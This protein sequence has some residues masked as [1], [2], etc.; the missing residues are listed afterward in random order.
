MSLS[1]AVEP[2][3][4]SFPAMYEVVLAHGRSIR[5]PLQFDPEAL[6]RLIPVVESC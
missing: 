5:I 6:S 3:N 1:N 4:P 2:A